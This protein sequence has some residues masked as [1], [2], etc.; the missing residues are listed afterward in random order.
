MVETNK[1][2]KAFLDMLAWSEGTEKKGQPTNNRGYDVIV[3][4]SLFTDYSDHPRKLVTLNPKLKSTA[5]GRYQ[6]L[7]RWW[8]A[9]RKQLGL[10]DF[11]PASQ[12]AVALQQIKE[13]R[14]LELIDSGDIL[15]AID[16]CSNIWASLP[17]AGYGQFEHKADNLIAKFKE[18][19]GTVNEPKS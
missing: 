16:R 18:A 10:K 5:A 12:D 2:R 19:G 8:D 13:R 14:A 9:Y 7:S 1:Q 6:L 11:S 15:Q 4:G 3:G 17:G